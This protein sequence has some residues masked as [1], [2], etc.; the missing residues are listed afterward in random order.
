MTESV[1]AHAESLTGNSSASRWW[2]RVEE[3]LVNVQLYPDGRAHIWCEP[4]VANWKQHHERAAALMAAAK[5]AAS[6]ANHC[7]GK[8]YQEATVTECLAHL[9]QRSNLIADYPGEPL[10]FRRLCPGLQAALAQTEAA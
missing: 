4:G 8:V 5:L 9:R 6:V 7:D 1:Q 10:H 3:V 2:L